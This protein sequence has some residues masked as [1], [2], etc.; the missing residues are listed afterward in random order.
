MDALHDFL[1]GVVDISGLIL[2]TAILIGLFVVVVI[3]VIDVNQ[4]QQAIRRNYPVIGRLR[5]FFEHL[6]VFFR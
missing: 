1:L 3:Y 4:T 6:G 5:Y 2:A